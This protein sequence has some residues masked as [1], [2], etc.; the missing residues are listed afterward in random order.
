M[1]RFGSFGA[2]AQKQSPA[3][4]GPGRVQS[5]GMNAQGGNVT[6]GFGVVSMT[7][8]DLGYDGLDRHGGWLADDKVALRWRR[9]LRFRRP[10]MPRR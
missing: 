3:R 6:Y 1:G 9:C 4:R 8:R 7:G 5:V 10:L 2:R